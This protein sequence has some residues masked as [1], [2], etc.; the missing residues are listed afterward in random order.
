[1]VS[2]GIEA[3]PVLIK[4][5]LH[6]FGDAN[7]EESKAV[8]RKSIELGC[9]LWDT[10]DMY[11]FANSFG[12]N[13]KLLGEV[14]AEGNIR[15]KVFLVTKWGFDETFQL[16]GSPEYARKAIDAS[17]ARLGTTPDAWIVHRI[18]KDVPIK[19]L[20]EV[21]EEVRKAGKVRFI[22][23][24]ECSARTLRE[25]AKYGKIDFI[26]SEY[27][28]FCLDIEDRGVLDA[29]KELDVKIL[30]F[31]PLGKGFCNNHLSPP[32]RSGPISL[33]S[34]PAQ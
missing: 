16:N 8:L 14:L 32:L 13:E 27:S 4:I 25:A 20:V 19:D 10:A 31:S 6:Q 34:R 5:L 15:E 26:E 33:T 29:C 3:L 12:H 9:S 7:D 11:G 18:P 24:G 30:A 23:I 1:M 22:G 17:I 28:P 21:M 2:G